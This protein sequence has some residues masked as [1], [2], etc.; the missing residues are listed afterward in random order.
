M[1]NNRGGLAP[2]WIL[3]VIPASVALAFRPVAPA[4]A[5]TVAA[6]VG[7]LGLLAPVPPAAGDGTHRPRWLAATGGIAE[8]EMLR[9]FNCGI[10]MV[11]V[12]EAAGADAVAAV[13][14]CEG[15]TVVRLGAVEPVGADAA[16]VSYRG[17]IDLG[18]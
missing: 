5:L 1:K 15:E 13:L 3:C 6:A 11:A 9:T 14:A 17:R 7:L 2:F 12:V 18:G 8:P 10:G 16:P 4:G